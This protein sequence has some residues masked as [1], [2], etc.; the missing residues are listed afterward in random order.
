MTLR[1]AAAQLGCRVKTV[2]NLLSAHRADLP[3]ARYVLGD[4][5]Q[6][7]RVLDD[8]LLERL[9]ILLAAKRASWPRGDAARSPGSSVSSALT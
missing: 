4:Y 2:R 5:G 6:S 3:P 9:R 1:A 7:Y 8:E